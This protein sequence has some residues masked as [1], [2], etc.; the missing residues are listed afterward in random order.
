MAEKES[1][2]KKKKKAVSFIFV[3]GKKKTKIR[4]PFCHFPQ[5]RHGRQMLA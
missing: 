2:E 1:K 5:K 4:T 3:R